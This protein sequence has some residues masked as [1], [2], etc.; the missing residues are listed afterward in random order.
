MSA[1]LQVPN[2]PLEGFIRLPALCALCGFRKTKVYGLMKAG[3]CPKPVKAGRASLWPVDE[4]RRFLE[5]IRNGRL[6]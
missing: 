5:D 2:L 6:A 4:V 1:N 3:L